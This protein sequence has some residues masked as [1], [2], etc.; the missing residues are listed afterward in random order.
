MTIYHGWTPNGYKPRTIADDRRDVR[1]MAKLIQAQIASGFY[2]R[3]PH[4]YRLD[5]LEL[6]ERDAQLAASKAKQL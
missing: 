4:L 3:H 1:D 6:A 5:M 2:R